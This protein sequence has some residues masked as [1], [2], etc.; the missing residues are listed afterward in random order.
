MLLKEGF[1]SIPSKGWLSIL[2]SFILLK[3]SLMVE[4]SVLFS[5]LD[6]KDCCKL[7][8][9]CYSMKRWIINNVTFV[10]LENFFR[11][12]SSAVKLL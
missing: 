8:E 3:L 9:L 4:V 10:E 2:S 11:K 12:V 5:E 7:E 1:K 6:F